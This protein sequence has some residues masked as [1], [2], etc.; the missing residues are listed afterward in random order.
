ML[1]SLFALLLC[2]PANAK[3]NFSFAVVGDSQGAEGSDMIAWDIFSGLVDSMN[4]HDPAYLLVAGDLVSGAYS[5]S[6]VKL[7][8]EDFNFLIEPFVGDT[9]MVPGNHD[10]YSGTGVFSAWRETFPWLP[11]DDSP[12][13]EEGVSYY[14]D[15]G[16]SRF[17]FI[18]SDGPNQYGYVSTKGLNW[19]DRVLAESDAT[20]IEHIFV[21]T[22]HPVSFGDN[23]HGGTAGDFWQLM[24]SYNVAGVFSGHWHRYQPSQLGAGGD[25]WETIIGTGGGWQGFEPIRPYQQIPGFL[26]VEV[27]GSQVNAT[28]YGD[29]DGDGDYDD[30]LD[31]Y[32]MVWAGEEPRGLVAR[33]T[34][35]ENNANDS[36]NEILTGNIHGELVGNAEIVT[37]GISGSALH[38]DGSSDTV[39]AGSIAG[40]RLSINGDLTLSIWAKAD[41]PIS[42]DSWGAVLTT[43]ATNDYYTEDEETNYSYWLSVLSDGSLSTFWEYGFGTNESTTSSTPSSLT[44]GDWHHVVMVRDADAML[45]KYYVDG[46]QLGEPASFTQL[47]TG[48]GRGMLYIGSDTAYYLGGSNDFSGHLDELCIFNEMLD[49]EQILALST[50]NDCDSISTTTTTTTTTGTTT[51]GTTTETGSTTTTTATSTD[52]TTT[53]TDDTDVAPTDGDA[54]DC[55]CSA[56][57]VPHGLIALLLPLIGY[58]RRQ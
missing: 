48:G 39:E 40:Y 7:Q 58:R 38:L 3:D 9:Y 6:E 31:Q 21:V 57:T 10:V 1:L 43:F 45:V 4:D 18:T 44:D 2:I 27:D 24:V 15:H 28:F 55:G 34:F 37:E 56:T 26:L 54:S 30:A 22:H 20:G 52:T 47:P 32:T 13:G 5:H 35:D 16:D 11:T 19:L 23:Y 53:E 46:V 51:T 25:T 14:I 29:E 12:A 49:S 17:I 50:L 42:T 8:W 33:Y 36:G 41:T